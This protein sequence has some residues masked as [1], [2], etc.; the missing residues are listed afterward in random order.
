MYK[1]PKKIKI[2]IDS[3]KNPI[4]HIAGLAFDNFIATDAYKKAVE[5][6]P[7]YHK[8]N[9]KFKDIEKIFPNISYRMINDWD[10]KGLLVNHR[11]NTEKGWR[12]FSLQDVIRLK[13]IQD[14]KSYGMSNDSILNCIND[15]FEPDKEHKM[16]FFEFFYFIAFLK[17]RSVIVVTKDGHAAFF[18][19][20]DYYL[21]YNNGYSCAEPL[22]ILPFAQYV[23]QLTG[24]QLEAE[25][26]FNTL[27]VVDEKQKRQ[28]TA[29]ADKIADT[30]YTG[31]SIERKSRHDNDYLVMKS[32]KVET[33]Q[34][35]TGEDLLKK[36][37]NK[38]FTNTTTVTDENGSLTIITEETD[39]LV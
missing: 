11:E 38:P 21:A 27:D 5:L 13:I 10:S 12:R 29:I 15:I 16:Y 17:R 4:L 24:S 2:D 19:E 22:L 36:V 1:M 6:S 30:T 32:K 26:L 7:V 14:L 23:A 35:L 28:I 20:K 18:R 39:K 8:P 3:N 34:K 33:K 31:Y 25:H 37:K 9:F